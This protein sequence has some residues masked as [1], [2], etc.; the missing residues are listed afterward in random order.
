M[1]TSHLSH[2]WMMNMNRTINDTLFHIGL[3]MKQKNICIYNHTSNR[4]RQIPLDR[5]P[6]LPIYSIYYHNHDSVFLIFD[7]L[8][9]YVDTTNP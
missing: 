3:D 1:D 2:W 5:I 4:V 7:R 8:S 9:V 6:K